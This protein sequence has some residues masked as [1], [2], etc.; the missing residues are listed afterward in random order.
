MPGRTLAR[1]GRPGTPEAAAAQDAP[2]LADVQAPATARSVP[3]GPGGSARGPLDAWHEDLDWLPAAP[4]PGGRTSRFG[5]I[6]HARAA[7]IAVQVPEAM[8]PSQ[9]AYHVAFLD[10][11][12]AVAAS[13]AEARAREPGLTCNDWT[14]RNPFVPAGPKDARDA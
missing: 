3:T 12:Y 11:E 5:R 2:S 14:R 7:S 9:I 4:P 10:H 8:L 6:E 13:F 1:P